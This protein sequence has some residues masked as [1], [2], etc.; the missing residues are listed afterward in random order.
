LLTFWSGIAGGIFAP[1]LAIGAAIGSDI[2]TLMHVPIASCALVGMAGFLSGTIQAPITSFVIIFEMTGHHQM[3]LPVMLASLIGFMVARLLGAEHLY[4]ALCV[5]Y[6]YLLGGAPEV[7]P[8]R[9]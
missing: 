4:Q 5:N 8:R 2:G 7:E 6:E 1:C 3:L 9:H